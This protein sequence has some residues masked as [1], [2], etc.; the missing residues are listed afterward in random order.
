MC[1]E[2]RRR[3]LLREAFRSEGEGLL[4]V[5]AEGKKLC[6]TSNHRCSSEIR[7]HTL[8]SATCKVRG[9]TLQVFFKW[10]EKDATRS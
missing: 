10:L 3:G 6:S 2:K 1:L 8:S 5:R 9:H 4:A 7:A